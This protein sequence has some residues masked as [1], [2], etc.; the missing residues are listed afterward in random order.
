M[1]CPACGFAPDDANE[2]QP[3]CP[4]CGTIEP[5]FAL[6]EEWDEE[7]AAWYREVVGEA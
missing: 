2:S 4:A 7:L 3:V 6:E 1:S 5:S